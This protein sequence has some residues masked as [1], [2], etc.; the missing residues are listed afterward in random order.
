MLRSN[1]LIVP[2]IFKLYYSHEYVRDR[3]TLYKFSHKR[4]SRKNNPS[5]NSQVTCFNAK[6]SNTSLKLDCVPTIV[7][8]HCLKTLV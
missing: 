1:N 3:Q 8:C 5:I 6:R 7:R 2:I 4:G